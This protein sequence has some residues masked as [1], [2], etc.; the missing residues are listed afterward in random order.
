MGDIREVD[1][2]KE[3]DCNDNSDEGATK[4]APGDDWDDVDGVG[5]E[6][7]DVGDLN[8]VDTEEDLCDATDDIELDIEN[9]A[10]EDA[11]CE[12]DVEEVD[13]EDV[14][15][16]EQGVEVDV[17]EVDIGNEE[18]VSAEDIGV[19]KNRKQGLSSHKL[20]QEEEVGDN[21]N[22]LNTSGQA[23]ESTVELAEEV[24]MQPSKSQAGGI[25]EMEMNQHPPTIYNNSSNDEK[26]EDEE[27]QEEQ[28]M[29]HKEEQEEG[30]L[31]LNKNT[32]T[33]S[34]KAGEKSTNSSSSSASEDLESFFHSQLNRFGSF[35]NKH[36]GGP[37]KHEDKKLTPKKKLTTT[38]DLSSL[39][40]EHTPPPSPPPPQS[41]SSPPSPT[42]PTKTKLNSKP[43][44]NVQS[45][46]PPPPTPKRPASANLP[47]PLSQRLPFKPKA[48]VLS[49]GTKPPDELAQSAKQ[50]SKEAQKKYV[51]VTRK[52]HKGA[53]SQENGNEA[54][55][56]DI[57]KA[58]LE[59]E[60]L[61]L[62][63]KEVALRR[64][65]TLE[66]ERQ[67]KEAEDLELQTA[68][69]KKAEQEEAK[70][71]QHQQFIEFRRL[72]RQEEQEARRQKEEQK[73]FENKALYDGIAKTPLYQHLAQTYKEKRDK[74]KQQLT[75]H[76]NRGGQISPRRATQPPSASSAHPYQ[77]PS[78]QA[79]SYPPQ[80]NWHEE[81]GVLAERFATKSDSASKPI[82]KGK[83]S[84]QASLWLRQRRAEVSAAKLKAADQLKK[85][86]QYA[87]LVREMFAPAVDS[88][89]RAEVSIRQATTKNHRVARP[90]KVPV[91]PHPEEPKTI[92]PEARGKVKP[93]DLV[94]PEIKP[95]HILGDKENVVLQFGNIRIV[96]SAKQIAEDR[97]ATVA[98]WQTRA[99]AVLFAITQKEV[100]L[101]TDSLAHLHIQFAKHSMVTEMY[102][103]TISAKLDLLEELCS[104]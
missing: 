46:A 71:L 86:T 20:I 48:P 16:V 98:Q 3:M 103:D 39:E 81:E 25:A 58:R 28:E 72:K 30:E 79:I 26:E 45:R 17:E 49:L 50:K 11:G 43:K 12:V 90:N 62:W 42:L 61:R 14:G 37:F 19:N 82:Y 6:V 64:K 41:P 76:K 47:T 15:E 21:K 59:I 2:S 92:P 75:K 8:C 91:V 56:S 7:I 104:M 94:A 96:K 35:S 100:Q 78:G 68:E 97:E 57:E 69:R 27:E 18:L 89:K 84:V 63:H 36:K 13:V 95:G 101:T 53:N 24:E 32:S 85:Q 80:Q 33:L 99:K 23:S 29:E 77:P 9:I 66:L 83:T 5:D 40:L 54:L 44:S 55:T 22:T 51:E 31:K 4:H 52:I 38:T 65:R 60:R 87:V 102:C 67:R 93:K 1:T 10:I 73:Y 88:E 34:T 74:A 70:L